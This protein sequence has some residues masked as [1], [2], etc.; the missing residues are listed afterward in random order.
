MTRQGLRAAIGARLREARITA[1][2]TQEDVA[3]ELLRTRQSVS[4]W[5]SGRALP[6]LDEFCLI[7]MLYGVEAS[8]LLHGIG[9]V[10]TAGNA[11]VVRAMDQARIT[12]AIAKA[13]LR[14]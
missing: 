14:E 4:A 13:E 3:S 11:T 2:L 6:L 1:K 9:D 5:E 12:A 8:K 10:A 7:S